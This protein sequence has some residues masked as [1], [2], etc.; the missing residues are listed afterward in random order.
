MTEE[1]WGNRQKIHRYLSAGC[2]V[3]VNSDTL[4]KKEM[5]VSLMDYRCVSV[6]AVPYFRS[7]EEWHCGVVTWA[8]ER[9]KF[10]E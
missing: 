2:N 6:F 5:W 1:D 10:Q 3:T 9:E 4:Y 7:K 8:R